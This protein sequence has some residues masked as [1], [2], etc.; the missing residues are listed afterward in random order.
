MPHPESSRVLDYSIVKASWQGP[1]VPPS[2][3]EGA[4]DFPTHWLRSHCAWSVFVFVFV[5]EHVEGRAS[6]YGVLSTESL[7]GG[8]CFR[9]L[10][11]VC[12]LG[13]SG[14]FKLLELGPRPLQLLGCWPLVHLGT[15]FGAGSLS[16]LHLDECFGSCLVWQRL[17][18]NTHVL[19]GCLP[20]LHCL[21][22]RVVRNGYV[23]EY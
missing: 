6:V 17:F 12:A 13:H 20:R 4:S 7:P 2:S 10:G 22:S 15:V 8:L 16:F 19:P 11:S 14:T 5:W 9:L 21:D 23:T 3:R 1:G 18:T